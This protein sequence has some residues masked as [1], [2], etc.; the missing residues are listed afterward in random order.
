MD[1]SG[2]QEFHRVKLLAAGMGL[3]VI[4]FC[5]HSLVE[6]LQ[7]YGLIRFQEERQGQLE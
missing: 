2:Y 4:F 3:V 5:L 7:E 6:W 1:A